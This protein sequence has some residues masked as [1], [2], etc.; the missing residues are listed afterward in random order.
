MWHVWLVWILTTLSVRVC[1][2]CRRPPILRTVQEYF[3][4]AWQGQT[5]YVWTGQTT[6]SGLR[7][8]AQHLIALTE[9]CMQ[10]WTGLHAG[11]SRTAC[12]TEKSYVEGSIGHTVRFIHGTS[13]QGQ[14]RSLL[15]L[16]K[17]SWNPF[18][19]S[20][21][22]LLF[23]PSPVDFVP[24]KA[25]HSS[26]VVLFLGWARGLR[27]YWSIALLGWPML[28]GETLPQNSEI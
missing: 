18:W 3:W 24:P 4:R 27:H 25:A 26:L 7:C 14:T 1:E 13:R 28:Q 2:S 21:H 11:L 12:R 20:M 9:E 6:E 10:D 22:T 16:V 19:C 5:Q 23:P 17:S 15:G 8:W